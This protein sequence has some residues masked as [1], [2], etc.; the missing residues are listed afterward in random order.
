MALPRL[1]VHAMSFV[2]LSTFLE[3]VQGLGA[4]AFGRDDGRT[5][6]TILKSRYIT[7][8]PWMVRG[9]LEIGDGPARSVTNASVSTTREQSMTAEFLTLLV[10]ESYGDV[11]INARR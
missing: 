6:E 4:D 5:L 3:G 8:K 1:P 2:K 9:P 11:E 7:R 10:D